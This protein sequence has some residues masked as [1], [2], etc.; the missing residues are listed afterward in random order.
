[1]TP[2]TRRVSRSR[3]PTNSAHAVVQAAGPQ[4]PLR[5]LKA[6]ALSQQHGALGHA[7]ILSK[8]GTSQT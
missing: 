3:Q 7:H 5:D 6:A 8:H 1:M 2:A 4:A